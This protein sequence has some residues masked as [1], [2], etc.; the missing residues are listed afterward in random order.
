MAIYYQVKVK[1]TNTVVFDDILA[2]SEKE[3]RQV[4]EY[5]AEQEFSDKMKKYE[6]TSQ[7][8]SQEDEKV[9]VA[10]YSKPSRDIGDPV[11]P[12]YVNVYEVRANHKIERSS[13]WDKKPYYQLR[14]FSPKGY[15]EKFYHHVDAFYVEEFPY[16]NEAFAKQAASNWASGIKKLDLDYCGDSVPT[17]LGNGYGSYG[18]LK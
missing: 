13:E 15:G 16:E 2:N 6:V 11:E 12:N 7:A 4:A 18:R 9:F 8:F 17:G 10:T 3:A 14:Y 1:Q 5:N